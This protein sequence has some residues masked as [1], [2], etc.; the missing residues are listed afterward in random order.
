MSMGRTTED[1][2]FLSTRRSRTANCGHTGIENASPI[3][4]IPR[5]APNSETTVY[6]DVRGC[7]ASAA[8]VTLLQHH[9]IRALFLSYAIKILRAKGWTLIDADA[10][11]RD[12]I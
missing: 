9:L 12:P 2:E 4:G 11:F 6:F 10:A 3:A 5:P 1:Y 8:H 7:R